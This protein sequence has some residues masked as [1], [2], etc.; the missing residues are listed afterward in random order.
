MGKGDKKMFY[1]KKKQLHTITGCTLPQLVGMSVIIVFFY[2]TASLNLFIRGPTPKEIIPYFQYTYSG[3]NSIFPLF[4]QK[5]LAQLN[6]VY[7]C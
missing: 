6:F 5:L 7:S 4:A 3:K 2:V 1:L